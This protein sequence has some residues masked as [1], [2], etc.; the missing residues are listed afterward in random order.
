MITGWDEVV[1]V[2]ALVVV[3]SASIAVGFMALWGWRNID[4]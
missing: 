2:F 1:V 3:F 4:R